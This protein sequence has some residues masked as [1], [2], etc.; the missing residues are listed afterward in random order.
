MVGVVFWLG[1]IYVKYVSYVRETQ[2]SLRLS[3]SSKKGSSAWRVVVQAKRGP[4]PGACGALWCTFKASSQS[5]LRAA[6]QEEAGK[7]HSTT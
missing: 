3:K 6:T 2:F 5:Y 7:R 1:S 4:V